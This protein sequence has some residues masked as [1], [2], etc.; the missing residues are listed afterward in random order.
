LNS[1]KYILFWK[2]LSVDDILRNIHTEFAEEVH[3]ILRFWIKYM[4]DHNTGGFYGHMSNDFKVLRKHNKHVV[5]QLRGLW[6]FSY[7]ARI[8]ENE[9]YAAIS[10]EM[11]RYVKAA[12]W[13]DIKHGFIWQTNYSGDPIDQRKF[14]YAQTFGI[15]A[16]AERYA[17]S[18]DES[19]MTMALDLFNIIE[20]R[21]KDANGRT[22][23]STCDKNWNVLPHQRM[24]P[25]TGDA[26][27]DVGVLLHLYEAYALLYKHCGSAIVL[28]A[29]V[30]LEILFE[31]K[32]YDPSTG[33]LYLYLDS[34]LSPV[35]KESRPGHDVEFAWLAIDASQHFNKQL[36][37]STV[38]VAL[39]SIDTIRLLTDK[40]TSTLYFTKSIKGRK[41]K[42]WRW[43]D[44][45]EMILA[46]W[47]AY[48]VTGQEKYLRECWACWKFV[49]R[50]MRVRGQGVW[51]WNVRVPKRGYSGYL[52][53]D[54]KAPYHTVRAMGLV[55]KGAAA[56][57]E[58]RSSQRGSS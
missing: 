52:A 41:V 7:A 16:L 9:E 22:Y 25:G 11:F 24:Q 48:E 32:M 3:L 18:G 15:Y 33:L 51:K 47:H 43:W 12:F 10:K 31:E 1:L 2:K 46:L 13:D 17:L 44:Q 26:P 20:E 6:A 39:K 42:N 53:G 37:E 56:T 8:F 35:S 57:I 5:L 14:L 19:A 28:T 29:L 23:I 55:S 30:E 50:R 34:G 49:K 38:N 58:K 27:V 40:K 36:K 54:W 21:C 4:I 45:A